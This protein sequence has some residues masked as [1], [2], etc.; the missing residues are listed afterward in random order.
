MYALILGTKIVAMMGNFVVMR[1]LSI[2]SEWIIFQ[3]VFQPPNV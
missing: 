1:A 2:I 3:H